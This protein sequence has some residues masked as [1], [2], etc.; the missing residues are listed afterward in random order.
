MN[1]KHYLDAAV[2]AMNGG[3]PEEAEMLLRK[4]AISGD[5]AALLSARARFAALWPSPAA[6]LAAA[7][8][9]IREIA[10]AQPVQIHQ[11]VTTLAYGD[12]VGNCVRLAAKVLQSWGFPSI[13]FAE[14]ADERLQGEWVWFGEHQ[15]VSRPQSLLLYHPSDGRSPMIPYLAQVPDRKILYYHNITPAS[16]FAPW[17]ALNATICDTARQALRH[18]QPCIEA[19]ICDSAYNVSDLREL[20]YSQPAAVVPIPIFREE[21]TARTPDPEVLRRY[22]DGTPAILFVGRIAPNKCQHELIE[23]LRHYHSLHGRAPRLIL[24]GATNGTASYLAAIERLRAA[25]PELDIV[26]TGHTTPE[27]LA[28]YYTVS[29]AFVCLSAHEGFCIPLLEA[30][31]YRLPILA[32]AGSAITETLGG[33]GVLAQ[34]RDLTQLANELHR[35]LC[36]ESL[37]SSI[38]QQQD[39]RVAEFSEEAYRLRLAEA[40]LP[41]L[42]SRST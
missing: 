38:I 20:G 1:Q 33:A 23:L 4:A 39:Q 10:T 19:A 3:K 29:T 31:H 25:H 5:S 34:S 11:C 22:R 9:R 8:Q 26:L 6:K 36:D 12:G 15:R 32:C 24:A 41:L 30:M 7:E 2:R 40:L 27:Q 14:G 13:I 17:D 18:L 21:L 42:E 28:A 37:R 35:L 16:F